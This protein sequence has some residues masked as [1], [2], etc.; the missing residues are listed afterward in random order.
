MSNFL[1]QT[2]IP[3][4]EYS[5]IPSG[6]HETCSTKNTVI[7]ASCRISETFN[8]LCLPAVF[9]VRRLYGGVEGLPAVILVRHFCGGLEDWPAEDLMATSFT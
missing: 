8:Y 9:L 1:I 2:N 7:S 6:L 5:T 3:I 4:F